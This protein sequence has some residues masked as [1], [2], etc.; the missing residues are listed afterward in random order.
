MDL[1]ATY[2][3]ESSELAEEALAS[4]RRRLAVYLRRYFPE[5]DI[6][7]G[8]PMGDMFVSEMGFFIAAAEEAMSRMRSDLT[9]QNIAAGT[10]Y[11]CAFV[12][13]WLKNYAAL[14]RE[15]VPASGVIR[16]IF[17][18]DQDYEIDRRA[19]YL[20]GSDA[21]F[22]LRLPHDGPLLLKR[23]GIPID[24][25]SNQVP[26]V[27][28]STTQYAADVWV[29]GTMP[30]SV[31]KT[32]ATGKTDFDIECLD[33]I[34]ALVDFDPGI[35]SD[36]L[37]AMAARTRTASHSATL[38]NRVGAVAFLTHEFPAL[39][40]VSPV[41]SGDEEAMRAAFNPL[42]IATGGMDIYVRSKYANTLLQQQV[43]LTYYETQDGDPADWFVGTWTPTSPISKLVSVVPT[44]TALDLGVRGEDVVLFSRSKNNIKAPMLVS[45][46]SPAEEYWL[47]V[48]MPR[49]TSGTPLLSPLVDGASG[50]EYLWFTASY[51]TD[52]I[53]PIVYDYVTAPDV[54]PS[55]SLVHVRGFNL[56]DIS[57]MDVE[58]R[59]KPGTL[60]NLKSAQAEIY[61]YMNSLG[62]VDAQYSDGPIIDAMY[63]AGASAVTAIRAQGKLLWTAADYVMDENTTSPITSVETALAES[64]APHLIEVTNS[65]G[66]IPTWREAVSGG[67]T[68]FQAVGRR[69]VAY[70][71]PQNAI[72]F[73]EA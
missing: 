6:R 50:T 1:I 46:H 67:G 63:Y 43:K 52:P 42:G 25:N 44:G 47:A 15:S 30:S 14:A 17:S 72:Q 20:F 51:V 37:A 36:S 65:A 70:L 38:N 34:T 7:P 35:T 68:L 54:A 10:V 3:P 53:I 19:Q 11:D 49:T 21:L 62:G 33:S 48:R 73:S 27:Q 40:A 61:A 59:R 57:L 18:K 64:Y 24:G 2:F 28:I 39:S 13:G 16:L 9:L 32:G 69:N 66:F 58:Y 8:T 56:L 41:M 60:V 55:G 23:V 31:V 45:G 29:E 4:A 5:N 26:L 22:S 71:V 12:E